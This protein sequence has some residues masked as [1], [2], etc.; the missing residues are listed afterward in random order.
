[1]DNT[2]QQNYFLEDPKTSDDFHCSYTTARQNIDYHPNLTNFST[3]NADYS[4]PEKY[5][6]T[7]DKTDPKNG[8]LF[9]FNPERQ[10]YFESGSSLNNHFL[11]QYPSNVHQ[12]TQQFQTHLNNQHNFLDR[13]YMDQQQQMS[14]RKMYYPFYNNNNPQILQ[15]AVPQTMIQ[16]TNARFGVIF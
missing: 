3:S 8:C 12:P 2:N 10:N 9:E 11:Y 7:S 13:C 1:M 14:Q 6:T 4:D 5:F 16:T 15:K